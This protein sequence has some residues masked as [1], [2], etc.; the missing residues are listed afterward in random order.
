LILQQKTASGY[1]RL[2]FFVILGGCLNATA[3]CSVFYVLQIK[4]LN[5]EDDSSRLRGEN[6]LFF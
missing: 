6:I 3:P 2:P 1:C 4:V 5:H